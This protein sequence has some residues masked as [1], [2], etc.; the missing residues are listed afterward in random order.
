[1]EEKQHLGVQP[2]PPSQGH[3]LWS[4]GQEGGQLESWGRG[5]GGVGPSGGT[6]HPLLLTPSETYTQEQTTKMSLSHLF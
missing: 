3:T 6:P 1:M 2:R 4:Q 5:S